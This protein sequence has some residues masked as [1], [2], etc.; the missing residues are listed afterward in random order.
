MNKEIIKEKKVYIGLD[1]SYNSTGLVIQT[2]YNDKIYYIQLVANSV[3]HS[4]S[5]IYTQYGRIMSKE[6]D[7]SEDEKNRIKSSFNLFQKVKYYLNLYVPDAD[8]YQFALE[9]NVMSSFGSSKFNRLTDMV[10]LNTMM[11]YFIMCYKKSK[12]EIITPTQIKKMFTGNGRGN[13]ELVMETFKSI[14]KDDFIYQG[15][16]DDISDAYALSWIA[17]YLEY[18]VNEQPWN[19]RERLKAEKIKEE[20]KRIREEKKRLREEAKN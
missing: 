8:V 16:W 7:F 9:G 5:V 4:P 15:K 18:P 6:K 12:L 17:K 13:K 11:K 20:K 14:I 2:N 3:P 1:A 10:L 19:V